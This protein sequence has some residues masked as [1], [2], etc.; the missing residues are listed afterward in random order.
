M[1]SNFHSKAMSVLLSLG[2]KLIPIEAQVLASLKTAAE[3]D[4]YWDTLSRLGNALSDLPI[5]LHNIQVKATAAGLVPQLE[6]LK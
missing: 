4:A 3:N 2:N 6:A 1:G 5:I